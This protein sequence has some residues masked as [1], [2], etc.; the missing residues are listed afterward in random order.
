MEREEGS[1]WVG[2]KEKQNTHRLL[3]CHTPLLFSHSTHSRSPPPSRDSADAAASRPSTAAAPGSNG[4]PASLH[5]DGTLIY[6]KLPADIAD[7]HVLLMDPMLGTGNS[8]VTALQ[9]LLSRGVDEGRILMLTLIAAPEGIHRVCR[10]F[11][12]VRL[13]TTE[14]DEG[15]DPVTGRVTPGVGE[16]GDRYFSA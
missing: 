1:V 14:I 9:V 6:E 11:P 10:A 7:R 3:T 12:R 15:L 16:F 13:I 5:S 8:A 4:G 2:G